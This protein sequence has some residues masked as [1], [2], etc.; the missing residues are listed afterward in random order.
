[1]ISTSQG[2]T[3]VPSNNKEGGQTTKLVFFI[4]VQHNHIPNKKLISYS[5]VWNI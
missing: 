4:E 3:E 5:F 1:M 2:I